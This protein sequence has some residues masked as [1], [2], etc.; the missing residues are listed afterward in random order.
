MTKEVYESIKTALLNSIEKDEAAQEARQ[1]ALALCS[2]P[3]K[4]DAFRSML[5]DER[6]TNDGWNKIG[7]NPSKY[8]DADVKLHKLQNQLSAIIS[9][10]KKRKNKAASTGTKDDKTVAQLLDEKATLQTRINAIDLK[11]AAKQQLAA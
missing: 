3:A 6:E 1:S 8:S 11:I 2:T 10:E 7:D 9:R 4:Q 5:I